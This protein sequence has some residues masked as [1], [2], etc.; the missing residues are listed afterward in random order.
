VAHSIDVD[1]DV[2]ELLKQH[3]EPLVDTPNTVLRRLLG[4]AHSAVRARSSSAD[5]HA[6][7]DDV[8]AIPGTLL[9]EREYELP[10]LRYLDR[11][12]G[13][14]PSREVVEAV[15]EELADRLT[16]LDRRPLKSGGIRWEKRAAFVRLRLIERGE[17]AND[18]PRGTWEISDKGNE[19]LEAAR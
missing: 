3:A 8:R 18:S 9:A 2:F 16:E 4:I 14:A 15:G 19:R 12:G 5:K 7:S 17:L 6:S 10:I 11:C 13:R 1:D